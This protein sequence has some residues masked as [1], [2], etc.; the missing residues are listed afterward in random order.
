MMIQMTTFG[1]YEIRERLYSGGSTVLYRGFRPEDESSAVLKVLDG[2]PPEPER[3]SALQ[4]EHE[5]LQTIA[6]PGIIATRGLAREGGQWALLLEDFGARSLADLNI[7]G[8]LELSEFLELAQ[9][10]VDIIAH[11]HRQHVVHK[12]INPA[13]LLMNPET[14]VVK[15]IDFGIATVLAQE[16]TDFEGPST[17]EGSLAY[18]SPEQTGRMNRAIDYRTDYYSLGVTLYELLTGRRPFETDDPLELVHCHIVHPPL[19]PCELD[20]AIPRALS[21]IVLAL[22]A[23]NT[24]DRYQSTRGILS[25]LQRCA[26]ELNEHGHIAD[27]A[28]RAHD[29]SE[30]FQ[31]PQTLYGRTREVETLIAAFETASAGQAS[32]MLVSGYAGIGKSALIQELYRPLTSQRGYFISGKFEQYRNHT[33]YLALIQALRSL[34]HHVLTETED[35][36]EVWRR[37]LIDALES[38]IQALVAICPD[39]ALIVGQQ[40]D[41]D[42]LSP[43]DAPNR[44][45]QAVR[46]LLS[47]FASQEHPLAIFFDDLQ[48]ADADSLMLLEELMYT[49]RSLP[50]FLIGAYRDNEVGDVHPLA[51]T[52]GRIAEFG[53][54]VEHLKLAPLGFADALAMIT[55]TLSIDEMR[56]RSL[57]EVMLAHT[58]GNPFFLRA[59]F[60]DL[61]TDGALVLGENDWHWNIEHIRQR[62]VTDNVVD[63]VVGRIQR[64][65]A[66][67]QHL[68]EL[69]ACVGSRFDLGTLAIV[70]DREVGSVGTVLWDAVS[71]GLVLVR[72]KVHSAI[73]MA[74]ASIRC[75]FAHDRIQQAVIS[76]ID[77]VTRPQ[78]HYRVGRRL[79]L[80]TDSE[81]QEQR[82]FDIVGQLNHGRA[83]IEDRIECRQLARLNL[84]AADKALKAAA[85]QPAI[86]YART[87]IELLG[88]EAWSEDY[89]L[90]RDLHL[91]G[92]KAAFV[93]ADMDLL[94][95]LSATALERARTPIDRAQIWKLE[96]Q[97]HYAEQRLVEGI[98]TYLHALAELGVELPETASEAYRAEQMKATTAAIAARLNGRPI[99]DLQL[100]PECRDPSMR[101]AMEILD[102]MVLL[103]YT[104]ASE[105]FG[106]IICRLVQLSLEFGNTL[107]S[108]FGYIFYGVLLSYEDQLKRAYSFGRLGLRLADH[109]DD[110]EI[111]SRTYLY[112]HYQLIHWQQPLYEFW[113]QLLHA[114]RCGVE[115]GSRF[116]AAA[117]ASTLCIDR[118][119]AGDRLDKLATDMAGYTEV[120]QQYRQSLVL[121]W[122]QVYEQAVYNLC[123]DVAE[124]CE[125]AGH[126]YDEAVRVP[127]HL[128]HID[129]AS[130]FNYHYCKAFLCYLFGD[131][132]RAAHSATENDKYRSIMAT[133]LWA[134]PW[135]FLESL[136]Q[137]AV[138]PQAD[139]ERRAHIEDVVARNQAKLA[140]WRP[141]CPANYAHR[142][143]L[144]AA[145]YARVRGDTERARTTFDSA[146]E[147]ARQSGYRH[148][149]A[150]ACELAARFHLQQ[151]RGKLA[152]Y[153]LRDAHQGYL[154][155][156]AVAKVRALEQAYPYALPRVASGSLS[157]RT[158]ATVHAG[159]WDFNVLD[160]ASVLH[161]SHAISQEIALDRLLV[162][163]MQ[164]V[165]ETA[166][167]KLGYLLLERSGTW[168]LKVQKTI[169]RDEITVSNSIPIT[170]LSTRGHRGLPQSLVHYVA[171]TQESVVLEN[172]TLSPQFGRDPYI[173][174]HGARSVLCLPLIRQGAIKGAIYLE[175]NQLEGIFTEERTRILELLSTQAVISLENALLYDTL[176]QQVATRTRELFDKNEELASA[177]ARLRETQNRMVVQ[178]RLASLGSLTAGIAHE[179]R[180]PLNFVN[181][182]ARVSAHTADGLAAFLPRVGDHMDAE[183]RTHLTDA[184]ARLAL[185]VS[186][187]VEHGGRIDSIIQSM[188]AHSRASSGHKRETD[189]NALLDQYAALAYH[190]MRTRDDGFYFDLKLDLDP[191]MGPIAI[192]PQDL[193][194]VILNLIDNAC[195]ALKSKRNTVSDSSSYSP[196]LQIVSRD[197]GQRV[198]IRIRDNGTGIPEAYR[199]KISDP[200]FTTKDTG[201]GTGLGLSLSHEVIVQGHGGKLDFETSE[202]EFTEFIITLPRK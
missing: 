156:G 191:A 114:Y 6:A 146:V 78:M 42:S 161:A 104:S 160:L 117:S 132:E 169:D 79:L 182:F 143:E 39:L 80:H 131:F 126:A 44:F 123:Q 57:A 187:I 144:V 1:G 139:D 86:S 166:G 142:H 4:H 108:I 113:P 5:I 164:L 64:L 10:I 121:N 183:T 27:F 105:L 13:N 199:D 158:M 110:K 163:L 9:T 26:R 111:L 30:R 198:E 74:S 189:V 193:G 165:I 179:L 17:L 170:E 122:H 174:E 147:M 127:E 53:G 177:L 171:R 135:A 58:A 38:D 43:M 155:W 176:E 192:V 124:P 3:V 99:A 194:R 150:L 141:H 69:A 68:L 201:E 2:N 40:P 46:E 52:T 72:D 197:L 23:K 18:I 188:L 55:D 14:R 67:T 98:R 81:E 91:E 85:A 96:G 87:G 200:F 115:A 19:P 83:V 180:N 22:M 152:R 76:T 159:D 28:P 24:G 190:G 202:G 101:E 172:A 148:E 45:H 107:Y 133:A 167:A 136:C 128:A 103:A 41:G 112:A 151:G 154:R 92:C 37:Q 94:R 61:Y 125:L 12:D 137:L 36:I 84:R 35:R 88:P 50:I 195:H 75:R 186:K 48:W 178:N 70:A 173:V 89:Q 118:F 185:N 153:Y 116:N 8:T 90:T 129:A 145:E 51:V 97:V 95:Q 49:A 175:N 196:R 11:V 63:L 168:V 184:L 120:M 34:V 106:L 15:L 93:G 60:A 102:H 47:V 130:M 25:D 109:Y 16:A 162:R 77:E 149:E 134:A 82:L 29:R 138:Y 20:P 157:A 66:A 21:D 73:E 32:L 59:F 54:R 7:A 31:L 56:A 119:L 100:L 181:N 71:E 33:P 62:G 65:P 140:T